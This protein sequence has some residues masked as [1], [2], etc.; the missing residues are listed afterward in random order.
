MT[1]LSS[2]L[3]VCH[4]IIIILDQIKEARGSLLAAVLVYIR[5]QHVSHTDF[6]M[7]EYNNAKHQNQ[8]FRGITCPNPIFSLSEVHWMHTWVHSLGVEPMTRCFARPAELCFSPFYLCLMCDGSLRKFVL[9]IKWF[10]V[11]VLF[12]WWRLWKC[13][14]SWKG[15]CGNRTGWR[16]RAP[17]VSPEKTP[18]ICPSVAVLEYV[19][20]A[21]SVTWNSLSLSF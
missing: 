18:H 15:K 20:A 3:F 14:D 7:F 4:C 8:H 6:S 9:L 16:G 10:P 2:A 13:N 1:K 12:C 19:A 11:D 21:E 17:P 5:Y